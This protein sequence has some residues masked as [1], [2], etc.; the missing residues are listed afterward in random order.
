MESSSSD[1][2]ETYLIETSNSKENNNNNKRL[3]KGNKKSSSIS[4]NSRQTRDSTPAKP[5]IFRKKG[6]RRKQEDLEEEE[7]EIQINKQKKPSESYI[8]QLKPEKAL[9]YDVDLTLLF[10]SRLGIFSPTLFLYLIKSL[11][12]HLLDSVLNFFLFQFFHNYIALG[13]GILSGLWF[14][15]TLAY[16]GFSDSKKT[17]VPFSL[18]GPDRCGVF[19][20]IQGLGSLISQSIGLYVL[21]VFSFPSNLDIYVNWTI[22]IIIITNIIWTLIQVVGAGAFL[23]KR[24]KKWKRTWRVVQV[25]AFIALIGSAACFIF[26]L[27]DVYC[28]LDF[29]V[30]VSDNQFEHISDTNEYEALEPLFEFEEHNHTNCWHPVCNSFCFRCSE[31]KKRGGNEMCFVVRRFALVCLTIF[32]AL[33]AF[34]F[35]WFLATRSKVSKNSWIASLVRVL[36]TIVFLIYFAFSA[37]PFMTFRLQLSDALNRDNWTFVDGLEGHAQLFCPPNSPVNCSTLDV[38]W[39]PG[40]GYILT[41]TAWCLLFIPF[42]WGIPFIIFKYCVEKRVSKYTT[43]ALLTN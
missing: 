11:I 16:L 31:Y 42:I 36:S 40:T 7:E 35:I 37:F 20:V 26:I 21:L 30:S 1:N 9:L 41:V 14:I 18:R 22:T 39:K 2:E 10:F 33:L 29:H 3:E 43:N 32:S 24:K 23:L 27:M 38:E 8:Q 28:W 34:L 25:F 6:F 5:D 17:S 4:F 19:I 15:S 12:T 13:G